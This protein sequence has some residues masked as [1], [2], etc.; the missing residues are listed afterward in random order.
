MVSILNNSTTQA[1]N[2]TVLANIPSEI[3]SLG[4]LQINGVPTSG[5]IV[6]GVNIG[7]IAPSTSKSVTFEGRTQTISAQATK[8]AMVTVRVS[9]RDQ[10]DSISMDLTIGQ[11]AGASVSS[12]Q[13]SSGFMAF[14]RRWYAWI[15]GGIIMISLF[16]IVFRR[17]SSNT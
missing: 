17:L 13:A 6:S 4:N 9:D 3:T 11:V 8:Q 2:V 7:S 16:I 10:S 12:A 14:L 1:D 15:I 5:D